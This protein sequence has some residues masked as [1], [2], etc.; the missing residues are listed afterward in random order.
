MSYIRWKMGEVSWVVVGGGGGG[1]SGLEGGNQMNRGSGESDDR[2]R[3]D[4]QW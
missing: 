4:G 3:Q 2:C 1:G